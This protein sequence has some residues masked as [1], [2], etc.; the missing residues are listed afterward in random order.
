MID[1]NDGYNVA[2]KQRKLLSMMKDFHEFCIKKEIKYSII[3]GT[4][5]GAIRD[6]GFIPWDD[7]VDIL[8]DRSNFTKLEKTAFDMD[9]YYLRELL[10]VY[11]IVAKEYCDSGTIDEDTP[12]LDIFI[13]DR[14]PEGAFKKKLKLFNLKM[15]QGM[16]KT[17]I[18]TNKHFSLASKAALIVTRV[19]GKFFSTEKKQDFYDSV[20]KWG[21]K[22]D[23]QPLMIC[24]DIFQSIHCEY[25]PNLMSDYTM[26]NFEDTE[27]MAINNWANYLEEQYGDYMT[28]VRREH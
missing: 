4:L 17:R 12:V 16:M 8:M 7:D 19:L 11:K 3:G 6:K 22:N 1:V 20:S 15:L 23:N 9:G 5:L 28:P 25:D 14:V 26:V 24:N 21:N 27:L 2:D 18:N 10:W 13:V